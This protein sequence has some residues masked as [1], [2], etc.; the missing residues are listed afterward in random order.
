MSTIYGYCRISRKSQNI[1]RQIRNIK[2]FEPKAVIVQEAFSGRTLARPEWQ[3]LLSNV[4]QGDTI[5][6]DS[7]SRMSRNADDGIQ[8]YMELF[9]KG[10]NLIFLKERHID[11]ATY[12]Q[13]LQNSIQSVG[14]DIADSI[15]KQPIRCLCCLL[16]SKFSLPFNSPKKK[17][18]ICERE[19]ARA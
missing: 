5:I 9:D 3:R 2:A 7:V 19:R 13:A 16:N 12:C 17:L 4:K 1:E 8:V 18:T 15:L 10:V 11:T 14:N 6:F